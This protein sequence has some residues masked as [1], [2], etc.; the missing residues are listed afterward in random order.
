MRE[1]ELGKIMEN[2]AGHMG[3]KQQQWD[4]DLLQSDHSKLLSFWSTTCQTG[5]TRGAMDYQGIGWRLKGKTG[6]RHTGAHHHQD[7]EPLRVDIAPYAHMHTPHVQ[8]THNNKRCRNKAWQREK[9]D[10]CW[11]TFFLAA[12]PRTVTEDNQTVMHFHNSRY[13]RCN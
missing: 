3:C 8:H 7:K 6:Q 4:L 5:E 9:K 12:Y 11:I 13:K 2:I 1:H 10:S